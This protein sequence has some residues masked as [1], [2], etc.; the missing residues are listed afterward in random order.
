MF[1]VGTLV[2]V[3][4]DDNLYEIVGTFNKKYLV[5]EVDAVQPVTHHVW[6]K[7]IKGA[8]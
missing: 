6:P 8:I 7:E 2:Y 4:W 5:R 3:T 1:K